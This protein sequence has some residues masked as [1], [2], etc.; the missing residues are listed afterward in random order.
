MTLE[1]CTSLCGIETTGSNG[2]EAHQPLDVSRVTRSFAHC[3]VQNDCTPAQLIEA[4]NLLLD[5]A[6]EQIQEKAKPSSTR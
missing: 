6:I 2:T 4:A 5:Q 1:R 3:L